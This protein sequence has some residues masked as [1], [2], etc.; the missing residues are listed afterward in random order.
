MVLE[1]VPAD[2]AQ[3]PEETWEPPPNEAWSE[4]VHAEGIP[5][6]GTTPSQTEVH[7]EALPAPPESPSA[8]ALMAANETGLDA[9]T[10]AALPDLSGFTAM[11]LDDSGLSWEDQRDLPRR[12]P[13]LFRKLQA[14]AERYSPVFWQD[15]SG[16]FEKNFQPWKDFFVRYDFDLTPEGP[17]W[18]EPPRFQDERKR[19]RNGFLGFAFSPSSA[20]EL[21]ADPEIRGMYRVQE[22]QTGE[23]IRLDLRPFVY[24]AVLTTPSHYFFHYVVFHAEDW[25]GLFGHTGDL[26]GTTIVVDRET[27]R[28]TAAFTLAHDDVDVVRSLEED[29]ELNI[30]ILVDPEW[31]TRGLLEEDD[32]RPIDGLLGMDISRDGEATPKEH[33]DIYVETKGHGQYGPKKIK[34]SRYIIYAN[35]FDD[36]AFTSP[37]FRRDQYPE[38]DRFSEVL[39]KHKYELVYIGSGESSAEPTLWSQYRGLKRFSGGVNPPWNWRDNLWFK[40]GWWKDPRQIKKIGDNMYRINPYVEPAKANP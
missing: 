38:T 9:V 15:V 25:K 24:W 33:Q 6:Q 23:T 30:G 20:E 14:L 37:S 8:T 40:T 35:F 4:A 29:A 32:E 19:E 39:S 5:E 11:D 1:I 21:E 28:I 10:P 17:N 3:L 16:S 18:P 31:E 12:K 34:K 27:E 13:E 22:Q 26:E 2:Q 36:S 7:Q